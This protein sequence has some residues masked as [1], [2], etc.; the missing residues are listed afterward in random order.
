MPARQAPFRILAATD[1]RNTKCEK[2]VPIW[3]LK[4]YSA[5]LRSLSVQGVTCRCDPI[6][7]A[8]DPSDP[9]IVPVIMT[10]STEALPVTPKLVPEIVARESSDP[11]TV[12]VLKTPSTEPFPAI[13][14][15]VP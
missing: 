14:K 3:N 7:D 4:L 5:A 12:P 8:K 9:E 6:L 10:S 2:G 11:V 15:L 13:P 1:L